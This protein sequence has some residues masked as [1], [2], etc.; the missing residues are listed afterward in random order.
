MKSKIIL[1]GMMGCGK[2]AIG[3][4]LSERL[5]F[6][7]FES[8]EIFEKINNIFIKYYFSK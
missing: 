2:T 5:N 8:D 1:V 4:S 7:L 3:K 6:P